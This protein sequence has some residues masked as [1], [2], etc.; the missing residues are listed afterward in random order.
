MKLTLFDISPVSTQVDF[1]LSIVDDGGAKLSSIKLLYS[2][3]AGQ[4]W[5]S[6]EL[7]STTRPGLLS[8]LQPETQYHLRAQPR[9]EIG[10]LC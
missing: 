8:N 3:D 5:Q 4:T 10:E 1:N 2:Q 7:N 6:M 9:N